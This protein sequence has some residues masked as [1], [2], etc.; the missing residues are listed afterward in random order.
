MA[1]KKSRC[2]SR[3]PVF[4]I[5]FFLLLGVFC[6]SS[7]KVGSYLLGGAEQKQQFDQLSQLVQQN[8]E[9]FTP[10]KASESNA[11]SQ[12][13]TSPSEA[14]EPEIFPEYAALLELN[15]DTAGWIRIDGTVIDYPVMHTPEDP[16]KYLHK[17][18]EGEYS[19]AGVPFIDYRCTED[20]DNLVIYGHNMADGTM[21]HT[22]PQYEKKDHWQSHPVIR[23][24]SVYEEREYEVVAAFYDRIYYTHETDFKFYNF[25]D[26]ADQAEYDNAV[27]QFKKKSLYDTGVT[28]EY[29]QQLI[30]LVT[31]TYHV[32]NGRFVVVACEKE[33]HR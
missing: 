20:S 33:Q 29:G 9:A 11:D 7:W 12:E 4:Y 31:C 23:F 17:N 24:D 28:P 8:R 6:F 3:G 22:L 21:F 2:R 19:Y 25:I 1:K 16:E 26:A 27:E 32:D 10:G 18:F 15:P 5:L 30:T 14:T 13:E